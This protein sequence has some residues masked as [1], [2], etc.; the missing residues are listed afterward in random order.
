MIIITII[1]IIAIILV[2]YILPVIYNIWWFREAY[3][4]VKG[5]WMNSSPDN[6]MLFLTLFPIVNFI[7][8]MRNLMDSP[9][10]Y[11]YRKPSLAEKVFKKKKK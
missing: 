7:G 3:D 6:N 4:E 5:I 8:S 10:N 2:F 11:K 9:Y 1:A